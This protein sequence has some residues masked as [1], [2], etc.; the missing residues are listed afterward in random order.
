VPTS[1][2]NAHRRSWLKAAA[3]SVASSATLAMHPR[4]LAAPRQDFFNAIQQDDWPRVSTLL[5]DS[6]DINVR[7]G[8]GNGALF[9]AI[10][11]GSHNV[12]TQLLKHPDILIDPRNHAG[13]TPLMMAALRDHLTVAKAL[14][15]RGATLHQS[16]WAPVHYAATGPGAAVLKWLLEQGAPIEA[17][18]ASNHTP[19]MMAARYGSDAAIE[20][21]LKQGADVGAVNDQG[22]NASALALVAK[23]DVWAAALKR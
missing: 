15:A 18:A 16:G 17:R 1:N 23:R 8:H 20:W 11:S 7:D 21:L 3:W 9:L 12:T 4:V 2:P 19:L 22:Q 13:E 14:H 5:A 6:L 10:R